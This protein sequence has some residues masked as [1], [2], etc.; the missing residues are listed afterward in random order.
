MSWH[1]ETEII[2]AV[3]LIIVFVNAFSK[4]DKSRRR[5]R[6]FFYCLISAIIFSVVDISDSL[7]QLYWRNYAALFT[8]RT[9]YYLTSS[10][11][12]LLWFVYLFA[13]V[14]ENEEKKYR[15][16]FGFGFG[17]YTIF[18]GFIL[19]N[20]G[21][22]S[23]FDFDANLE[24]VHNWLFPISYGFC[25]FYALIFYLTLFINRK[26]IPNSELHIALASLPLI[27]WVGMLFEIFLPGWLMLG[28]AYS[29]ALLV[30]YLFIQNSTTQQLIGQLSY[31]A[32][33]DALT[34]LYNRASF[35]REMAAD[36]CSKKLRVVAL[37]LI[38]IDGLKGIND[39]LGHPIGDEAIHQV[40]AALQAE[41][42]DAK[43][44]AR[45]GGDEFAALVI[46]K[47][48]DEVENEVKR[49]LGVFQNVNVGDKQNAL[50]LRCSVGIAF[51]VDE[52]FTPETLYY[53]SDVALYS[54]KRGEKYSYAFYS[55]ELEEQYKNPKRKSV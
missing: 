45:I 37:L 51:S 15:M 23:I 20:I 42:R 32:S 53:H 43:I 48:Q 47:S 33:R 26:K 16:G 50:P 34:G 41:L 44:I 39:S 21:T 29:I 22:H 2:A 7:I 10:L 36:L 54:V 11:P 17:V 46:D 1:Y 27:V 40:G 4:L 55:P 38:D 49:L 6:V 5:D 30:A 24:T 8:I 19:A 31:Q 18:C 9:L 13:I 52:A 25:A 28:P 12:A 3:I 35:D 14:H